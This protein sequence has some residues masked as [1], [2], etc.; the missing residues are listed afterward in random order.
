MRSSIIY[1]YITWGDAKGR[2]CNSTENEQTCTKFHIPK[3]N[4]FGAKLD[5]INHV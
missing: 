4:H 3:N 1:T 2:P 5:K